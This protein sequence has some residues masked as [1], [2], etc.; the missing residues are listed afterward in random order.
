MDTLFHNITTVNYKKRLFLY[1]LLVFVVFSIAVVVFNLWREKEYRTEKLTSVLEAYSFVAERSGDELLPKDMRVT[2][3]DELGIVTYDNDVVDASTMVNHIDRPEVIQARMAGTGYNIRHSETTN[4]DYVYFARKTPEGYTRVALPYDDYTRSLLTPNSGFVIFV[5]AL[6]GLALVFL[7]LIARRFGQDLEGLKTNLTNEVKARAQLKTEMTSAIAHELRTPTSAIRGYSETLLEEGIDETHRQHFIQR[8]HLASLRLSE[9]LENISLLS[10]ME[11][12]PDRFS[13]TMVVV[14]EV[15]QEVVD[16]F[17]NVATKNGVEMIC[18]IPNDVIVTGNRTLIY[19]I[20]RNLVEN[21]IKYG[22][23]NI[24]VVLSLDNTQEDMYHFS[25]SDSGNSGI[26]EKHIPRLFERFYRV[27]SGRTRDDGGSGL[28]LSIV[29][30][31]VKHHCGEVSAT[32]NEYGGLTVNF[33]LKRG[34]TI[35]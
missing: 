27:D 28:G 4:K 9:L 30:H 11:E 15:A 34:E 8:I 32:R 13:S 21:A 3:I 19:S 10:K 5:V 24:K 16:E 26:E 31:A 17:S 25:L 2:R 18:E 6:G 23:S 20:W 12:A 1:F 14:A 7:W 29:A 22:G 35:H 33:S